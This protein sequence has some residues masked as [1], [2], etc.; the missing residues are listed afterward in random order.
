MLSGM[1]AITATVAKK[2]DI[3]TLTELLDRMGIQYKVDDSVKGGGLHNS[4]VDLSDE[5]LCLKL[6]PAFDEI[7]A[8]RLS[9]LT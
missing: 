4:V 8:R 9:T 7:K 2:K 3:K 6:A 1:T 5:E